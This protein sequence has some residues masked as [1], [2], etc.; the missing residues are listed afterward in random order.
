MSDQTD[1]LVAEHKDGK[2]N[3]YGLET[4][5]VGY[6]IFRLSGVEVTLAICSM[7]GAEF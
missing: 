2:R 7:P 3:V 5:F 6:L 4:S 1:L